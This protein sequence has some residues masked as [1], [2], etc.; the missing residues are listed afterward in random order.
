[1]N[2]IAALLQA[3]EYLE[4]IE[5]REKG[6]PVNL[7]VKFVKS[8]GLLGFDRFSLVCR[9][10]VSRWSP[11][12]SAEFWQI[13]FNVCSLLLKIT[14]ACSLNWAYLQK[15]IWLTRGFVT[16]QTFSKNT[17][18]WFITYFELQQILPKR[19]FSKFVFFDLKFT[20]FG[21]F[22]P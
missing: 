12:R 16:F 10:S 20:Y 11:V 8:F 1:M 13:L 3:A 5:R 21:R 2:S 6:K 15:N 19:N 18:K 4:S 9:I 14:I 17:C 22:S 7:K